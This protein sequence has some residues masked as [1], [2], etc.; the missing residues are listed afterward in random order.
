MRETPLRLAFADQG[1]PD[2]RPSPDCHGRWHSCRCPSRTATPAQSGVR[3]LLIRKEQEPRL[4]R[5]EG[6]GAR[7]QANR[8]AMTRQATGRPCHTLSPTRPRAGP[9]R[10]QQYR[11]PSWRRAP[12]RLLKQCGVSKVGHENQRLSQ[13]RPTRRSQPSSATSEAPS[14]HNK[15]APLGPRAHRQED[16]IIIPIVMRRRHPVNL[17][18]QLYLGK[19]AQC[20]RKPADHPR[21]PFRPTLS[22]KAIASEEPAQTAAEAVHAVDQVECVDDQQDPENGHGVGE[23]PQLSWTPKQLKTSIRRPRLTRTTAATT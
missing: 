9:E 13:R 1:V 2:A 3:A 20:S 23:Y 11:A 14:P 5:P 22:R 4:G 21:S 7:Q 19:A 16:E 17:A 18:G 8:G 10:R 15:T 6:I 12:E